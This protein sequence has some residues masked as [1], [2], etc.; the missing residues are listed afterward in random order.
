MSV[1]VSPTLHSP[2]L[3]VLT[4]M[5]TAGCCTLCVC[6][7]VYAGDCK[8]QCCCSGAASCV[9]RDADKAVQ[10][11][12]TQT[13]DACCQEGAAQTAACI[14][15]LSLVQ[16]WCAAS[17][18]ER[19]RRCRSCWGGWHIAAAHVCVRQMQPATCNGAGHGHCIANSSTLCCDRM[20]SGVSIHHCM[21]D[22]TFTARANLALPRCHS[23]L[24]PPPW[25]ATL[26]IRGDMT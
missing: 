23:W 3:S 9:C 26:Y 14:A 16:G 7:C 21:P 24:P 22:T 5:A 17:Q 6:L 19:R 1:L 25:C 12:S 15:L 18:A 10:T 2:G 11:A 20:V 8:Q 13:P 4:L